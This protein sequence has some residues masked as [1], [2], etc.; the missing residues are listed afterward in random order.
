MLKKNTIK[1]GEALNKV[2]SILVKKFLIY[3]PHSLG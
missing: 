3:N 1:N 2:I